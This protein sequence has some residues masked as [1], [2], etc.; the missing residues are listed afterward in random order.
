M[1]RK[2]YYANYSINNQTGYF[3]RI[4]LFNEKK[5]DELICECFDQENTEK[6]LYLLN[7]GL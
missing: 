1:K 3:S 7:G 4:Y 6:L 2:H 5:D